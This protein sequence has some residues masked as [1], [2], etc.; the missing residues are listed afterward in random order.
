[1]YCNTSLF[2]SLFKTVRLKNYVNIL[3]IIDIVTIGVPYSLLLLVYHHRCLRLGFDTFSSKYL[4]SASRHCQ[5]LDV[6]A[7]LLLSE[8]VSLLVSASVGFCGVL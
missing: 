7:F 1:M 4:S 3:S 5:R 8:V 6:V 2:F